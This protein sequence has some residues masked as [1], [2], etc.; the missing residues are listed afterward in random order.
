M[1]VCF[2]I[3]GNVAQHSAFSTRTTTNMLLLLL[4]YGIAY[5]GGNNDYNNNN[6]NSSLENLGTM[7]RGNIILVYNHIHL[8]T[9]RPSPILRAS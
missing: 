4:Y 1:C 6:M 8:L 9:V 2:R 5:F 7:A 3:Q